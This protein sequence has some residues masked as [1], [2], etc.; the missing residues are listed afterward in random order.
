MQRILAVT[1]AG[2]N[3]APLPA[4]AGVLTLRNVTLRDGFAR[5]GDGDDSRA[6]P[7][8][9][10]AGLGGAVFVDAA[11]TLH[12]ERCLLTESVAQGGNAGALDINARASGR[13]GGL[14]GPPSLLTNGAGGPNA[15]YVATGAGTIVL[16]GFGG[17]SQPET[18][19]SGYG[20]GATVGTRLMPGV[21]GGSGASTGSVPPSSGQFGG[22][23]DVM[24]VAGGGARLGGCVMSLGQVVVTNSTFASCRARGGR[25]T[26]NAATPRLIDGGAIGAAIFAFSGTTVIAFS[27]FAGNTVA[28]GPR[29]AAA[30]GAIYSRHGVF[31]E[32][33]S[34]DPRL[35]PLSDHGGPTRTTALLPGSSARNAG[36]AALAALSFPD[37]AGGVD[38]RGQPRA[39]GYPS[40]ALG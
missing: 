35:G 22:E 16:P 11:A 29:P 25:G 8:G 20:G 1:G 21:G 32:S 31:I 36:D 2:G 28:T 7:G 26:A 10:A 24:G 23:G 17:G 38:Q 9:G 30:E 3:G 12:I 18:S 19:Q 33:V 39:G 4:T 34:T 13:G 5:G 14:G 27:T 37:G 15:G 40:R 6:R